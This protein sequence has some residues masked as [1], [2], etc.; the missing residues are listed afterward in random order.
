MK[1][2]CNGCVAFALGTCELAYRTQTSGFGPGRKFRPAEEC[3][4]PLTIR[5]Y[6]LLRL[7]TRQVH[8]APGRETEAS[9]G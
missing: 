2:T 9:D 1:R 3:P 7:S 4:K 8:A 5:K 6:I